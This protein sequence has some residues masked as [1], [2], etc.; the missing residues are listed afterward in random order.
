MS[1]ELEFTVSEPTQLL[2][3]LLN[4]MSNKGRN[5]VK[6]LLTRGQV[7]VDNRVVTRHD[8]PLVAGQIVKILGSAV[9]SKKSP[10]NV[11][12]L[13]EDETLMVVEKPPGLLSVAT[14][15]E[16]DHTAYRI[17]TDYVQSRDPK[18]RIFIV[19]RLDRDTSGVMMFA[20]SEEIQ[21]S[22]QNTWR[23]SV[24]ERS[25]V[26]VVEGQVH[27]N[28]GTIETWLQESSTKTMYVTRPGIGVKATTHYT[29]LKTTPDY[30]MLEVHLETGRKNQI[31]VH[32]Q[33]I[34]HPVIGDKRYGAKKNPIGRLGLHARILAF[35]HPKTEETIRCET[36]IPPAFKKLFAKSKLNQ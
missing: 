23:D 10:T 3:F 12:I 30:S 19:H 25:Y 24:L 16:R 5:K 36:S 4:T 6:A 17:L 27:Q 18:S 1:R 8:H 20:R 21:Q 28:E 35:R 33:S 22:L 34:G 11:R 26:V 2:P 31:R 13:F 7:T 32:M 9:D 15:T 29:V 14:E